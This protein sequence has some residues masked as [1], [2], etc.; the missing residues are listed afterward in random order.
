M[1]ISNVNLLLSQIAGHVVVVILSLCIVVPMIFHQKDFDDHCLLFSVGDWNENSGLFAVQWAS[2]FYCYFTRITGYVL[3]LVSGIEIY[4]WDEH[5]ILVVCKFYSVLNGFSSIFFGEIFSFKTI[6]IGYRT[7][8]ID[9]FG[10][11]HG[12][13]VQSDS[14]FNGIWLSY[15]DNTWLY[16]VVFPYNA[17]FSVVC[18]LIYF[19]SLFTPISLL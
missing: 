12:Y 14:M 7:K 13:S 8:G 6:A 3:I 10:T 5:D 17:S 15:Y 9:I 19:I 2:I 4:R 18:I 11:F 16:Q 1:A